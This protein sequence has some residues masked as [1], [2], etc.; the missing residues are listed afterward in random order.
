MCRKPSAKQ[1]VLIRFENPE[2]A[3]ERAAVHAINAS[4][5]GRANEADLVD[6]L[7]RGAYALI[8]LVADI[9]GLIVGHI[10]FSRMWIETPT[11]QLAAVALA[12]VAVHPR[13]QHQGIGGCL[14]THGLALLR[15]RGEKIVIVVGSP[16]YYPKFGF[17]S[18]R[19]RF[20]NSPFPPEALMAIEI[21]PGVLD[22][23]RGRV[24]YPSVFGV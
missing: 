19:T 5:F 3:D 2:S 13:Y 16:D 8:S 17:S 20:L 22:D 12:P 18:D 23:V 11:G 6:R 7:R 9:E 24:I 1:S 4:A 10:M 14:V 15:D 21:I